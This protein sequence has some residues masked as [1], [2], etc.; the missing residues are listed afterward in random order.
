MIVGEVRGDELLAMLDAMTQGQDG[1]MCTVHARSA[2]Q[3][4]ERF[5]MYGVRSDRRLAPEA[6][7]WMLADAL[8]L[9]V[10]LGGER[11]PTPGRPRRRVVETI[12]EVTGADGHRVAAN[13]V[14]TPDPNGVA[15][16]APGRPLS[17]QMLADL[18]AAGLPDDWWWTP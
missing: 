17:Q 14:F 2:R 8:D 6:T 12:L 15:T 7:A 3:V 16:P 18:T 1:S 13:E 10:Y 5:Q 4:F 9:V 11:T